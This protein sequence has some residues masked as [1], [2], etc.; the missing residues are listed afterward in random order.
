MEH[1]NAHIQP[2]RFGELLL[3]P[4]MEQFE[5]QGRNRKGKHMSLSFSMLHW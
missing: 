5:Y 1:K 4:S 3:L 2:L